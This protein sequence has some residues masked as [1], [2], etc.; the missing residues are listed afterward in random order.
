MADTFPLI[1]FF[2]PRLVPFTATEKEQELDGARFN[3]VMPIVL[4]PALAVIV[5]VQFPVRLLGVATTNPAGRVS[6]ADT[7][8]SVKLE[9]GFARVKVRD[10]VAFK[11]I[12]AAPKVLAMVGATGA[13]TFKLAVLLVAPGPLSLAEIGPV[14]LFS[15]P[16]V[17]GA[18]T[19][20][21]IVHEAN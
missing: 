11:G 10:V 17:P 2:V 20:T 12:V 3:A 7:F 16:T 18:F 6:V 21:E 14:V 9:F 13:T 8:V 4:L 1:L 19:F 15:V 5:A